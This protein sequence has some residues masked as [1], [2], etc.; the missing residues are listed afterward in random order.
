MGKI[1]K[2]V[3]KTKYYINT[4]PIWNLQAQGKKLVS[5]SSSGL[6]I[7][8]TKEIVIKGKVVLSKFYQAMLD[9]AERIH[10]LFCPIMRNDIS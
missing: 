2:S 3:N 10:T 1:N 7:G 9:G 4:F 5:C 6:S 8:V